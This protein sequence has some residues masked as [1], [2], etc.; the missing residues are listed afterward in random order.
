[1]RLVIYADQNDEARAIA[2]RIAGDVASGRRRPRQFAVFYRVNAL[3]LPFERAFR[4]LAVPYQLVQ[5]MEF[6]QRK[7]IRDVL[8][9]LQVIH[10]PRDDETLLRVINTPARG[11][12]RTTVERLADHGVSNGL[13]LLEAAR[14]CRAISSLAK[15]AAG[16][17]GKFV[18]LIDR[19]AALAD[20]PMEEI[21]GHVLTETGYKEQ[22]NNR[23][24]EEDQQ[25]LA[26]IEE[27]LT[28]AREFDER[29]AGEARLD[30][31]LEETSLVGDTDDWEAE[32]DR[33]TLMTLHASKGLEFPVVFLVAVEEGL[34]PHE[35]ARDNADQVEEERRLM[36]VGITRAREELQ[37]SYAF[38]RDW[39]GR[40]RSRF[41]ASSSRI[42][43]GVRW[44]RWTRGTMVR[45]ATAS[46][47]SPVRTC[48]QRLLPR[49]SAPPHRS[50]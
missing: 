10:N 34:L 26:N 11:I 19:L 7:E 49:R 27:L 1:M 24:S 12:G 9:Y 8:A 13:S 32:S 41:P 43:R 37:I 16:Q 17:V 38:Q 47:Q 29:H 35:R 28:V 39:A 21:L 46:R 23:E 42:C 45:R 5:G 40:G 14:D 36:F 20:A 30:E 31:F 25:R 4:E 15:R 22:Y 18:D 2:E 6:F 50:G 48:L 44:R 33:V 3:S